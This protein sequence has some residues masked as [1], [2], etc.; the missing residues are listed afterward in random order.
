V[1]ELRTRYHLSIILVSHDLASV[2]LF[3]DR[4]VYL[5]RSVISQGAP[6]AMLGDARVRRAFGTGPGLLP[7]G[8]RPETKGEAGQ[9]LD[10][11]LEAGP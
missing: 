11:S 8:R 9:C 2:A 1:S 3:A 10:C 7:R 6:A 4:V 5:N